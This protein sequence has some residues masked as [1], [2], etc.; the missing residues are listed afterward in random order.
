MM[1][2]WACIF[3]LA[4][5][6]AGCCLVD[7]DRR[8]CP[9]EGK[10]FSIDYEMRLVTNVQTEINTVLGLEE[11]VYVADA[12]RQHLRGIFSDFAH[13][14]DLSFYDVA[15][16]MDVLE[17][18]SDIIDANQTSYT[19]HLPVREYMHLAVA[20]IADN[21]LVDLEAEE[22]CGS[23][24]L[25]Q[26]GTDSGTIEP[27]NTGLFTA[28]LPM[29]VRANMDQ[30]FLV[31]LYMANCATALVLDKTGAPAISGFN[32]YTTGFADSF[33]IA[34]STYTYDSDFLVRA[35]E[36]P[37]EGGNERCWATVQFPSRE[38]PPVTRV[39]VETTDPFIA[40]NAEEI[41]WKWL[42][43]VTMP[44]GSV[45]ASTLGLR[46][47]LR[48]G[49]LKI[50][51][52]RMGDDGGVYTDDNNVAVSVQLNWQQGGEHIIDL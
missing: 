38:E 21:K 26:H 3:C 11:N 15:E 28:R 31:T 32:A 47:P 42:V 49:Q 27:H 41:I 5:L 2:S 16:P 43:Y 45:T 39:V 1:K 40:E 30:D 4:I 29:D 25:R 20:N 34:D 24:H 18:I 17:H 14:V 19:L 35:E 10:E 12:L 6:S 33:S 22:R 51:R 52:I 48:A 9:P 50:I 44:D 23:S 37:V 7:E 36:V 46:K 13:D 8:D